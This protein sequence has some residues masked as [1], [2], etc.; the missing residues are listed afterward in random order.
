MTVF[1]LMKDDFHDLLD[2]YPATAR[3]VAVREWVLCARARVCVP[4]VDQWEITSACCH[5]YSVRSGRRS[6]KDEGHGR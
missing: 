3:A 4:L 2:R 5:Y 6:S 1:A